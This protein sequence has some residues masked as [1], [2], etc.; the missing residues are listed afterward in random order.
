MIRLPSLILAALLTGCSS[1]PS[2][3]YVAHVGQATDSMS[4]VVALNLGWV[5]G[6]PVVAGNLWLLAA[7]P[8]LPA[9]I[10]FTPDEACQPLHRIFA[11][12]GF[13]PAIHN[14][15]LLLGAP[16]SVAWGALLVSVPILWDWVKRGSEE[17]CE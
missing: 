15:A 11:H 3:P 5:E 6:N 9:L 12:G 16:S 2:T 1:V 10:R 8:M 17:A 4:T 13:G 7:K 14:V